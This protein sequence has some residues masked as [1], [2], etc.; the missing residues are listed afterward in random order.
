MIDGQTPL[1]IY[2]SDCETVIQQVTQDLEKARLRVVRSFD[3]RS[4]CGSLDG[5][6]CPHHGT[7]PCDCQLV[8]L[9]VYGVGATPASLLLH[10]H[11][12]QTEIQCD[13]TPEARPNSE[14]KAQI[15]RVLNGGEVLPLLLERADAVAG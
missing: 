7:A 14:L 13:E 11:R 9:L 4:A 12:G 6:V 1:R 8:V 5:N 10:S 3:L 2:F 15:Y